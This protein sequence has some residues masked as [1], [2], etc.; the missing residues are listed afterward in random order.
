M[1]RLVRAVFMQN[2]LQ[3]RRQFGHA[4]V[5]T[6]LQA[7][8]AAD[9]APDTLG[10]L[11]LFYA[12]ADIAFVAGSLVPIGGHNLLE[13]AAR[14][15]QRSRRFL[16]PPTHTSLYFFFLLPP[17]PRPPR[18]PRRCDRAAARFAFASARAFSSAAG[19]GS[20]CPHCV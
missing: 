6:A 8:A 13:R 12:A 17:P 9:G 11:L 2:Q 10:E 4:D 14:T 15:P 7:A 16:S 20:G 1:R 3:R 19:E 5:V 18:P